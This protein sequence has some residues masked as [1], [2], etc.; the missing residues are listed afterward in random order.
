[1]N[2]VAYRVHSRRMLLLTVA[3]GTLPSAGWSDDRP[4]SDTEREQLESHYRAQVERLSTQIA[5]QPEEVSLYS[6]RGDAWFFLGEFD[7]ALADYE[8]TV[9]LQPTLDDSHW[10]RGIA[11]FY[12]G[13]YRKAAGQFE[14]YHS[15][16][17]I[18][19][20][21][22]IWRYL[23][24]YQ[25][26]GAERARKGLLKYE[27]DDRE[28]FPDVY[29]LFSKEVQPAAIL[30][31]IRAADLS[32]QE[33]QKRL[34]YAE[35]YIGLNESLEGRTEAARRHLTEAV[36]NRWPRNAGFGPHYMWHVGRLHL[37]QLSK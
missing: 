7:K 17:N 19:R 9:R 33:R 23:S 18:D 29:R 26:Y 12:A 36:R 15:F 11:Y 20:E 10:R 21:N 6:R 37:R 25:A 14:R 22:G 5:A 13:K 2:P 27:K 24:Q 32:P 4:L 35:L 30:E 28:P 3:L 34:F 8:Q 1:M 31:R 16:D